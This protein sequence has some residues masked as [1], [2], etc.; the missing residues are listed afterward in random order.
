VT[1]SDLRKAIRIRL[2]ALNPEV[3]ARK[4][5]AICRSVAHTPEWQTSR[6]I[7]FFSPL[8]NEPDIDLL[9][10]VLG[11][12]TVCYPRVQ[13][14]NLIFISVP[15]REALLESERWNLMEPPHSDERV[16][17]VEALD[18][19]FV[20]GIAFTAEGHR[21]G[22]GKGYY[23]RFL[24]Q[25]GFRATANGVCFAEQFVPHLPMEDHDRPVDRVFSA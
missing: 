19:L 15:D 4:S 13:G 7:G 8:P 25:P 16:M 11:E 21:M 24:V 14:D 17:P 23:D 1:K 3:K 22:R 5:A 6:V 20:P 12:R 9:W 10:A 2:E 18:F